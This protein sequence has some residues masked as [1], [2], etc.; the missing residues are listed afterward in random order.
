M[1]TRR[2]GG[3]RP[4]LM[5]LSPSAVNESGNSFLT[6]LM[7]SSVSTP[8]LR[9]SSWPVASV[10]V[11][12]SNMYWSG[13]S[14]Y[15]CPS[16]NRSLAV[17]SFSLA[18][19]AMPPGPMHSAIAG[20]PYS[21]IT[22]ARLAKREPSPSRFIELIMGLPGTC[23]IAARITSGSVESITSGASTSRL[24]LFTRFTMNS[25][26][27]DFSVVATQTSMQ[28][29]PSSACERPRLTSPS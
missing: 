1:R 4:K 15:F 10:N 28:W 5:L 3:V 19:F 8:A 18:V 20:V 7:P 16:S 24:S 14:P 27:S 26:S 9:N 21:A 29:A 23:R 12:T 25:S 2:A 17:S 22:G 6:S 13:A 11:R